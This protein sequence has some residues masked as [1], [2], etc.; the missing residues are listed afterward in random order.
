[1]F[2]SGTGAGNSHNSIE[3]SAFFRFYTRRGGG[4]RPVVRLD[5]PP[6]DETREIRRTLLTV[7]P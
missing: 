4:F 7:V 3:L 6:G 1:M 5:E 2:G